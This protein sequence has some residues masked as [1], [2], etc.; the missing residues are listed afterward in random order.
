MGMSL[1]ISER[2]L[3]CPLKLVLW[4]PITDEESDRLCAKTRGCVSNVRR[5]A[6][7]L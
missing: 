7:F 5:K 3:N 4:P 6:L 1:L 2:A